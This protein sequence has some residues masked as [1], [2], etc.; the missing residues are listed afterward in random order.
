MADLRIIKFPDKVSKE[1]LV[2]YY[3]K[4][5]LMAFLIIM[6]FLVFVQPFFLIIFN[7]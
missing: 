7:T 3:E 5:Y 2:N 1:Y 6:C 4:G